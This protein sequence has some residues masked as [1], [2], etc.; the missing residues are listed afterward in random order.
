M[1]VKEI[2]DELRRG[3]SE[4]LAKRRKI[5]LLSSIGLVDFAIITLY[6]TGIIK[7]LPEIIPSRAF[8]SNK[9]NASR[10]AYFLGVPDGPVS[11]V[12][13]ASTSVL[14]A[15]GG[16]EKSGRKPVFDWLLGAS[17][18]GNAAGAVYYLY[19]MAFKQKKACFYCLVGAAVNLASAAIVLSLLRKRFV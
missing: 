7:K 6:Q 3:H 16:I 14:A 13:Y 12:V 15:A 10:S 1:K 19:D 4:D 5:I 11:A 18:A 8:D 2:R 17:V 9:V